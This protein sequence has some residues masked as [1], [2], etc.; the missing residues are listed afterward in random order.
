MRLGPFFALL[1]LALSVPACAHS[2][3]YR[4]VDGTDGAAR[5]PGHVRVALLHLGAKKSGRET[6]QSALEDLAFNTG[7]A[8]KLIRIAA[9][10]GAQLVVTPEYGNT[11]NLIPERARPWLSTCVPLPDGVPLYEQEVDGLH[12]YVKS[13]SRLAAELKIWIVTD[14][15][16]CEK[17]EDGKRFYNCGLV[18]DDK[19]CV[20]ARYRKIYLWALTESNLDA[21]DEPT[22]FQTPFGRFGMLICSDALAPSLWTK[23]ANEQDADFIIMQSHWAPSPYVGT[24]AMGNIAGWTD[25]PVIWS[26]HPGFFAGGAG[27]VRPGFG[28]DTSIG[29]FGRAG[30]VIDDLLI[31]KRDT[32]AKLPE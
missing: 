22:T 10:R 14:V 18:L 30:V 20:R 29:T 1:G 5:K 26:N 3:N 4:V 24:F 7:E 2:D 16:E 32:T 23:L 21:G 19:G 8:E 27:V 17:V 25:K 13:Y 31:P 12:E 28:N 6:E 9:E 11:G 15:L